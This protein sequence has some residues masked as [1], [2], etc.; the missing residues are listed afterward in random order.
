MKIKNGFVAELFAVLW[1]F[2]QP[3]WKI[4]VLE[5]KYGIKK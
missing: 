1:I 4:S 5:D 2:L 3:P